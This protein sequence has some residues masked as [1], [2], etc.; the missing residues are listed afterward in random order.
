VKAK[1]L[2]CRG[3][4]KKSNFIIWVISLDQ[5]NS[6]VREKKSKQKPIFSSMILQFLKKNQFILLP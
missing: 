4:K 2:H 1:H 3:K 6:D 5:M